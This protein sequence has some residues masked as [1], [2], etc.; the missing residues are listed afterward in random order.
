MNFKNLILYKNYLL[1]LK[2]L[3][4]FIYFNRIAKERNLRETRKAIFI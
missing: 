4:N 2:N 1:L 3:V